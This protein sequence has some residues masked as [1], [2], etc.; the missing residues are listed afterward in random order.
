MSISDEHLISLIYEV[1]HS[2]TPQVEASD[3]ASVFS[4]VVDIEYDEPFDRVIKILFSK[5]PQGQHYT[6][7]AEYLLMILLKSP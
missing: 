4:L 7:V 2:H 3:P 6:K 1:Q 5:H